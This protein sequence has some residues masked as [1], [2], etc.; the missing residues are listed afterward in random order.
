M[1][2]NCIPN[3]IMYSVT[4][5]QNYGTKIQN[6]FNVL[7]VQLVLLIIFDLS[8]NGCCV[9]QYNMY[10]KKQNRRFLSTY[11]D[12]KI[13]ILYIN[14]TN[15]LLALYVF[16]VVFEWPWIVYLKKSW[17]RIKYNFIRSLFFKSCPVQKMLYNHILDE[18]SL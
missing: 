6:V 15:F 18:I 3:S 1:Y 14:T 11:I 17:N 9:L 5:S 4:I 7:Y 16:F 2:K 13:I 8:M 12:K 10:S